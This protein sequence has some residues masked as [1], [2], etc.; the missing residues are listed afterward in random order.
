MAT[1]Q[2]LIDESPDINEALSG[3]VEN[4]SAAVPE[5]SLI[6][7]NDMFDL[8]DAT[9]EPENNGILESVP[10]L[11]TGVI[12]SIVALVLLQAFETRHAASKAE[13]IERSSKLLA[14]S[15]QVS[16]DSNK[17]TKGDDNAFASLRDA[18][19]SA[20]SIID[21]LDQGDAERNAAPLP[22]AQISLLD[23]VMSHWRDVETNVD[24]ILGFR[25]SLSNTRDQV[26]LVNELAPLLLAR[27]DEVVDAVIVE[28]GDASAVNEAARQRGLSQRIVKDVNIYAKGEVD[29]AAAAG[30]IGRDLAEFQTAISQLRR[31]G[32]PITQAR[33]ED[34]DKTFNTMLA[35]ISSVF[36]DAAGFFEAQNA[37]LTVQE[38]TDE[39][40]PAV[41]DLVRGITNAKPAGITAYLPWLIGAVIVVLLF[42]LGRALINDARIRAELSAKQN[43]D[44]Q[45]AILKLLDEMGNLADGDLTIEAEVTD[46]I[47][48]AIADSVNFAVKE[49]RGLVTRI[50]DASRQVAKE[51]QATSATAQ[52][53]LIASAKQASQIT[54]TAETVESMSTSMEDMSTG[55][56]RSAEVAKNSVE[57]AKRG[58]RAV[59]GTIRGMDGMRDQI[60]ETSKR[61]KR[62]GE[63]SQQ[64]SDIVGLID[65]IAEQTNILSLNAA[66]QAAMAGEAGKGF[67]VVADEV[68]RL[69]ER[70]AEAT[71]QINNLVR[72]IQS[73]TNEAVIS[74]EHATQGVVDGTRVANG[75]GQALNEIENVSKHMSGLIG[76]MAQTAH[77][78]SES[79]TDVSAQM[80]FI[81]DVTRNTAQNAKHTAESIGKLTRLARDLEQS[82]AGFRIPG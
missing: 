47:T 23:P 70:S 31:T 67:A 46:Q 24:T 3:D 21:S 22:E 20:A 48:G 65:D 36:K 53:L 40:L 59:R 69:A 62:L 78:Q 8:E 39:L 77:A 14:L 50:N 52:A 17:A 19:Q 45:D 80:K 37:A 81:R 49:M 16:I 2:G 10:I 58:A 30:Q 54:K 72:N 56:L 29:A 27:S 61:I 60:Q 74:M 44:T 13:F 55:A 4:I 66:I 7:E 68:Q 75:A 1:V 5:D 33:L 26:K 73:D 79:A 71:K 41:Q 12:I 34:A 42:L 51:S 82:V 57:V 43:R 64:I 38:S 18:K 15:Q 32:G 35:S 25:D 11:I 6:P 28:S 63:S 9:Y 76:S